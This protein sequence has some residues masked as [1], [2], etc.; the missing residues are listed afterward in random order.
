MH[1]EILVEDVSGKKML[2]ILVPKI[3][4]EGTGRTFRVI[5]YK[6]IGRI[7]PGLKGEAD[8][9]KRIL[10]DRLPKVLQ[11]YGNTPSYRDGD[12]VV[13]VVCDLDD[14]CLKVFRQELLAVLERCDPRPE[15]RFC[16]AIQEGEAWLLGDIL[17]CARADFPSNLSAVGSFIRDNRRGIGGTWEHLA[18]IRYPGGAKALKKRGWQAVGAEKFR[19]AETISPHVDVDRNDSES[20]QYF[21]KKLLE[22]AG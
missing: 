10:L 7:P 18:D 2:D 22:L 13:F 5:P 1:F 4:G 16:I 14:K 9:A 17:A 8:P 12:S 19:W 6:G 21:R 15:T 11:G 3:L 20:F